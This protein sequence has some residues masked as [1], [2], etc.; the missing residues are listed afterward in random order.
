M[1][2]PNPGMDAVPFTP[3]T[4][5]FLDDMIE[6]IESLSDGTG[7]QNGA[8]T[9]NTLAESAVTAGKLDYTSVP[10]TAFMAAPYDPT[11]VSAVTTVN[12]GI[13]FGT[14]TLTIYYRCFNSATPTPGTYSTIATVDF[15]SVFPGTTANVIDMRI[16]GRFSPSN[17]ILVVGTDVAAVQRLSGKL[18]ATTKMVEVWGMFGSATAA[19]GTVM[20][21]VLA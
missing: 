14:K 3:L 12:T 7:F 11:K 13:K 5:E 19:Y 1:A 8:I 17:D 20:I 10:L 6:N 4:A 21:Y 9:T 2:L 18:S 15:T 16:T